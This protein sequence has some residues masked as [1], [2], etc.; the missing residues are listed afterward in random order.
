MA[1]QV[2]SR[3][4]M[5][6][7]GMSALALGP[8]TRQ[9]RGVEPGAWAERCCGPWREWLL[10]DDLLEDIPRWLEL[11]TVPGLALGVVEGDERWCRGFG[12]A[13]KERKSVVEEETLFE[14][15]SLGKPVCAWV[16]LRLVGR[17]A[18]DLDRPLAR[19]APLGPGGSDGRANKITARHVLTHTTGLPNWRTLKGPLVPLSEPGSTFSYSGE[20]FFWLQR[21]LEEIAAKPWEQLVTEEVFRPAGMTSSTYVWHPAFANQMAAGYDSDGKR[22]DVYATIGQ[23]L[24]GVAKKW[25]RPMAEWRAADAEKAVA[26]GLP[27]LVPVP[28]YTMPNAAGSFLTTIEDYTRFL[29]HVLEGSNGTHGVPTQLWREMV[30][31]KI[32]LNSA[33]SWGLGWGIQRDERGDVLWH[34]GANGTFRNFALVD[35]R[36]R[37]AVVV[38]T[39]S[40]NGT[41]LYPRVIEALTGREYPA[42]LYNRL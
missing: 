26:E 8:L 1:K 22:L 24:D 37:R 34:W 5:L 17:G 16:A 11:A 2:V 20:G 40:A 4:D 15:A 29:E 27:E 39:N 3:R 41:K 38:L 36:D 9:W 12:A 19:Y 31:P 10:T 6:R 13:C 35:L 28:I 32:A 23:R 14:G 21:A 33:L 30:T 18:L 42:F 25:N 7:A